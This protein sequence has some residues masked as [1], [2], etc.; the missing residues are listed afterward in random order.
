MVAR[1]TDMRTLRCTID[2]YPI[3]VS[4]EREAIKDPIRQ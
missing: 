4:G 3:K 1:K 2:K